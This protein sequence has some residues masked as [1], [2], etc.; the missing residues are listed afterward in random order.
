[1]GC[2]GER[3][4]SGQPVWVQFPDPLLTSCVTLGMMLNHSVP[5]SPYL[6]TR[7]KKSAQHAGLLVRME[8]RTW[9]MV[10]SPCLRACTQQSK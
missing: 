2:V 4:S 8:N 1:M 7:M 3:L 9:H 10:S 6:K 5:P